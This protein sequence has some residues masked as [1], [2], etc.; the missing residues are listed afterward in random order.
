MEHVHFQLITVE[1]VL[2]FAFEV[3]KAPFCSIH[4]PRKAKRRNR[5]A[6]RWDAQLKYVFYLRCDNS[7]EV[8]NLVE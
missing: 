3:A 2:K 8:S 5:G 7:S 4:E 1:Q 6:Q